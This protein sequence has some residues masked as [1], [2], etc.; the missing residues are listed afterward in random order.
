[1]VTTIEIQRREP[2]LGGRSFGEAGP[3]EKIAG[4]MRYAVDPEHPLHRRITD[5]E[6]AGRNARGQV[7][8]SG[9]FYLLR[10]AEPG[11]GNRRLFWDVPNRGRKS[12]LGLFNSTPR[13]PDPSTEQDFGNGF[14]M[15]R[16]YTLGWAGWQADLPRQE[17]V[18][19]L[20]APRAKGVVDFMRVEFRPHTRIA[21]MPLGDLS[22]FTCPSLPQPTVDTNDP[23]ARLS[24][25]ADSSAPETELPRP[26]WRFVDPLHIELDGGFTPGAIYNVVFRSAD[27]IV[28]GLGFLA[29]R[30]AAAFLRWAPA[31]SGNPCAGEID[32]VYLYGQSQN[33]RFIRHMLHLGLDEDCEG[34]MVFD[35]VWT[36][37][38][39]ARRGEFNMRFGQPSLMSSH[40][41]AMLP[42]FNDA[43]LYARLLGRGRVPKLFTTNSAWEYWRGD[44]SLVHTDIAGTRDAEPP[45]FARTY[46]FAGTQHTTGPIPPLAAE[47]NTGNR[48]HH[49]F[50]I[51]DDRPLM[52][53]ALVNLDRWAGEGIEPPASAFPRLADGTAVAHESLAALFRAI[54]GA[55]APAHIDRPVRLDFG[56]DAERGIAVYPPKTGAPYPTYV[57]RVDADGN[58]VAG[59]RAPE[60]RAPLATFM[61][62]NPRHE[63]QGAPGDIMLMMGSTLPFAR[64]RAE[65]ERE[66]DPRPSI[67]E[68]YPSREAYLAHVREE[69]LALVAAGHVLPED[70][71][72]ILERARAR[73][74]WIHSLSG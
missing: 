28:I 2:V 57:S 59:I 7:E 29:I 39:G 69:T 22:H 40:S 45:G 50:N 6:R 25:R 4:T 9:D 47:P 52:R 56:P 70:L 5:I 23:A 44:A 15:R 54:P 37:I 30:D 16:G 53:A 12:I 72:A 26:A 18:M 67:E 64:T 49:R 14:L 63:A 17:G 38:A 35:G 43:E 74:E 68:R 33:G 66:G 11:R 31:A 36:H 41:L 3:Y 61:G 10:P 34:R 46:F 60:L 58:E 8:F 55:R 24:V 71:A 19:A 20:E 65:R 27:P 48:G 1:M 51:V 13:S 21:T 73:W 62:W 42:P 32:R